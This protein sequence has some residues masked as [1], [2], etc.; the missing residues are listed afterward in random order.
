MNLELLKHAKCYIE[1]MANG[2][3]PLTNETVSDTDLINNVRISRCLFYVNNILGEVL[4]NE[5]IKN[6]RT[7]KIPFNLTKENLNNFEYSNTPIPI[8]IITKELNKLNT[9][10]E[11]SKLKTTNITNWLIDIGILFETEI[12]DKKYKLPTKMGE[13]IGLYIEERMG[14]NGEYYIVEYPKQSQK[15]I[16]DNFEGLI[17]YINKR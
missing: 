9:N 4:E 2:I 10:I 12:N 11:M 8:S 6:K 14:Y 5:G 13:D 3:N 16:I 15:F 1:K 7:K 17:D